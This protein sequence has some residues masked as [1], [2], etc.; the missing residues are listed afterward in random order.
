MFARTKSK[1]KIASIIKVRVVIV[2]NVISDRVWSRKGFEM[3]IETEYRNKYN[4]QKL[5]NR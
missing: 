5:Q 4:I 2:R 3:L 1:V